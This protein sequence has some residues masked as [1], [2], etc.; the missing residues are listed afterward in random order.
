M[1]VLPVPIPLELVVEWLAWAAL[2]E[3]LADPQA[4]AGRVRLGLPGEKAAQPPALRIVGPALAQRVMHSMDQRQREVCVPRFTGRARE[5]EE[6]A[7]RER[8]RPQIALPGSLGRQS[9]AFREA[10]HESCGILDSCALVELR[11]T[12]DGWGDEKECAAEVHVS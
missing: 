10:R 5:A 9:G 6:V 3:L 12:H 7:D 1:E 4:A 2:G 8:V 11:R